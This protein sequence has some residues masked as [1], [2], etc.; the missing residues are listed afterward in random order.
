M[1]DPVLDPGAVDIGLVPVG[2]ALGFGATDDVPVA[3]LLAKVPPDLATVGLVIGFLVGDAGDFTCDGFLV[4][5]FLVSCVISIGLEVSVTEIFSLCTGAGVTSSIS[6]G[7][8]E[9]GVTLT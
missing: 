1:E 3:D 4:S 8:G 7:R 2:F 9:D 5:T 6:W